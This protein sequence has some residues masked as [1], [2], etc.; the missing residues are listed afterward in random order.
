MKQ[1]CSFISE[2]EKLHFCLSFLRLKYIK[3]CLTHVSFADRNMFSFPEIILLSVICAC[4][5][6]SVQSQYT[7]DWESLDSRPLP[8]WY[9]QSKIGIFIHWSVF[10]VPSY[11]GGR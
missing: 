10:S 8:S 7:P 5:S 11:R 1:K 6:L 2:G 3:N 9:D 4:L